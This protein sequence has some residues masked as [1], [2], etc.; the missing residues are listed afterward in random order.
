MPSV[1]FGQ[2]HHSPG[3]EIRWYHGKLRPDSQCVLLH[4]STA[5]YRL[6]YRT[7]PFGGSNGV[8]S[9][10]P[11]DSSFSDNLPSLV[12]ISEKASIL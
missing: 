3:F 7:G 6:S 9:V 1:R 10:S 4:T 11:M 2:T 5:F 8:T 12:L